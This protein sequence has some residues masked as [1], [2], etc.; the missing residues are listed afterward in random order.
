MKIK[1]LK[2]EG[3]FERNY[4]IDFYE[5]IT[6]LYG[7][8]G[9]GKTT[10][11][12]ILSTIISGELYNLKRYD[13]KSLELFVSGNGSGESEEKLF[14]KETTHSIP[15]Y[16]VYFKGK[17]ALVPKE[18]NEI[19]FALDDGSYKKSSVSQS[20]NYMEREEF[21]EGKEDY[22]DKYYNELVYEIQEAFY[23]LYIP[24]TRKSVSIDQ[25]QRRNLG[26]GRKGLASYS[27][28]NTYL[29][30]SVKKAIKLLRDYMMTIT[31]RENRILERLKGQILNLALSSNEVEI[32]NLD[33]KDLF[34]L[35]SDLSEIPSIS[36]FNIPIEQNLSAL[37]E[38][39][40]S[41]RGSFEIEENNSIK[42][43]NPMG[44][45][46]FV[47]AMSQ[48][49]KFAQIAKTIN[50]TNRSRETFLLPVN[51]LIATIN[52]F[53]EDGEKE[54]LLDS[55][56]ILKF[57][58]RGSSKQRSISVMSSGEKQ[59]VMFFVYIILG[60]VN[61]T[62]KGIFIIDEPELSLHVEW[63]NKFIPNLL[64]VAGDTQLILATHSPEIIG[65]RTEKCV[66]V[67]GVL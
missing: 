5:D 40:E 31:M 36:N 10:I 3:L 45:A 27:D 55:R 62:R 66:E 43:I 6:L 46:N 52:E 19:E 30:N 34:Y 9:C 54:V 44:F 56:G 50:K 51:K 25:L 49:K 17:M 60:L 7:V 38:K 65:D 1:R 48:L 13:F 47:A 12:N 23:Q 8:N 61:E 21:L 29:D 35:N 59:I 2:I 37:K 42:I 22:F 58:R 28:A 11:L 24:L 67:R 14:I 63:Q 26:V 20:K 39:L 57:K 33:L 18:V 4:D 64:E 16:Q 32:D 53:L 41:C 15:M